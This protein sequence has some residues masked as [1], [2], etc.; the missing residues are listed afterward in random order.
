MSQAKAESVEDN[1]KTDLKSA[2]GYREVDQKCRVAFGKR[3]LDR[4]CRSP[5]AKRYSAFPT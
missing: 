2:R 4:D 3:G 5:V 1:G